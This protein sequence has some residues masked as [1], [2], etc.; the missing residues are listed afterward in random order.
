MVFQHFGETVFFIFRDWT[1]QY[2]K[3]LHFSKSSETAKDI[4]PEYFRNFGKPPTFH[5]ANSTQVARVL[6][7]QQ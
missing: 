2:C 4:N 5:D 3:A 6:S 7:K 1:T